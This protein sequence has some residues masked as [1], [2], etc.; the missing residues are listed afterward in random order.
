[1]SLILLWTTSTALAESPLPD[2]TT[3][4]ELMETRRFKPPEKFKALVVEIELDSEGERRFVSRERWFDYD[5]TSDDRDWNP[6]STVKLFAAIAALKK[7]EELKVSPQAQ[8]EIEGIKTPRYKKSVHNMVDLAVVPSDNLAFN[9]LAL[10]AGYDFLNGKVVQDLLRLR[11]TTVHWAYGS[12]SWKKLGGSKTLR[13]SPAVTLKGRRIKC[14]P[15]PEEQAECRT[16]CETRCA[17]RKRALKGKSCPKKCAAS[18]RKCPRTV[19]VAPRLSTTHYPCGE[20][21]CTTL[22]DLA[23]TMRRLML[24][25]ELAN[26]EE[27]GDDGTEVEGD[28][29]EAVLPDF[30]YWKIIVRAL[31]GHGRERG[32]NVRW[33]LYSGFGSQQV[34]IYDKPGYASDWYSDI[35]YILKPN[36]NKRWVV[37]LAAAPGRKSLDKAS[38]IIGAILASGELERSEHVP[39]ENHGPRAVRPDP[40]TNPGLGNPTSEQSETE[41]Y[42]SSSLSCASFMK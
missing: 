20:Q 4:P 18:C 28:G 24:Q 11:N 38:R 39:A 5:G 2:T 41:S 14:E 26:R 32:N 37:A 31:K 1:M 6:A 40:R 23:E 13:S 36:S 35:V 25:E 7:L 8:L 17:G 15:T 22:A 34:V 21:T 16:A 29:E 10:L 30:A 12:R 42:R 3:L 19:H 27:D 33:G 9:R